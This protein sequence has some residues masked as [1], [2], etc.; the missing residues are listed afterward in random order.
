[1]KKV[2]AILLFCCSVALA[3][4]TITFTGNFSVDNVG[5][6]ADSATLFIWYY[7]ALV[8]SVAVTEDVLKYD[9]MYVYSFD[10]DSGSAG[11]S[12]LWMFNDDSEN[13]WVN[14]F[15]WVTTASDSGTATISDADKLE[16]V[17]RSL[18]T[19]LLN[20]DSFKGGTGTGPDQLYVYVLN[21]ADSSAVTLVDVSVNTRYDATGTKWSTFTA[22]SGFALFHMNDGDSIL[23]QGT[24]VGYTVTQDSILKAAGTQ[25][26]TLWATG[27]SIPAPSSPHLATVY[28]DFYDGS[29]DPIKYAKAFFSLASPATDTSTGMLIGT[30]VIRAVSDTLGRIQT[31]LLMNKYLVPRVKWT[32]RIEHSRLPKTEVKFDIDDSTTSTYNF[33]VG[34]STTIE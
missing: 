28:G 17:S 2:I 15:A 4:H 10:T 13:I 20:A 9:G 29:G 21:T 25:Y 5:A 22:G 23:M 8:D 34:G 3:S 12:G 19:L 18:D 14:D 11:W 26:D 6:T 31:E 16:I 7:D 32:V 33:I 27:R 1:M 24:L 30:Q